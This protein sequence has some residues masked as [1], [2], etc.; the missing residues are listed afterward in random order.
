[1][2]ATDEIARVTHEANRAWQVVTADPAPSPPWDEAPAWQRGSAIEGV[3]QALAGAS[4][5]ELHDAWCRHKEEGAG[6]TGRSKTSARKRTRAWCRTPSCRK[7][8][9]GKA[10]YSPRSARR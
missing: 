4:A 1:M 2:T 3:R 10:R 8:S 5:E 7:G 6:S 9:G